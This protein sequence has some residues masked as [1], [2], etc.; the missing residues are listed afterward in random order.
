[1]TTTPVTPMMRNNVILVLVDQ[2]R[3]PVHMPAIQWDN[4]PGHKRLK[5]NGLRFSSYYVNTAPC[6]PSRSVIFTGWHTPRNL[7]TDNMDFDWIVP[8]SGDIPTLGDM[9]AAA[10]YYSVYKGKWHLAEIDDTHDPR[11]TTEDAMK[12]YG[13]NDYQHDGDLHSSGREGHTHDDKIMSEALYWLNDWVNYREEPAKGTPF[14]LVVGLVNP[15]DI[16]AVDVGQGQPAGSDEFMAVMSPPEHALYKQ[17]H[18]VSMPPSWQNDFI[19]GTSQRK[20]SAHAEADLVNSGLLG[21]IPKAR[22]DQWKAFVNYYI[23]CHRDVDRQIV[24]LL[25]YLRDT[26]LDK[27]TTVIFTADHGEI[28]GSHGMRNKG[29]YIYRENNH[30]PLVICQPGGP[31]GVESN[32]VASSLD[33]APTLN[34]L[35]GND[36]AYAHLYGAD[37]SPAILDP[38]W[39]GPTRDGVLYTYTA[40]SSVDVNI[41]TTGEIDYNKRGFLFGIQTKE[42][43][44]ARY[45]SPNTYNEYKGR[46][47]QVPY[48]D[49]TTTKFE[50]ELYRANDPDEIVNLAYDEAQQ[51]VVMSLND[52]LN[53]LLRQQLSGVTWNPVP[54]ANLPAASSYRVDTK[55]FR[56]GYR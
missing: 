18:G 25:D 43:K 53:A 44:F 4:L 24:R 1:M 36:V 15:H 35:F 3:M 32:V 56:A 48:S 20:P 8:M 50:L 45:F 27:T 9:A 54:P 38:T 33:L 5:D 17:D 49:I 39:A 19:Q 16:M 30:V 22:E 29:P 51:S 46:D 40:L 6:T 12:A 26:G 31:K 21:A 14:F 2:E 23:N 13:F 10:G 11:A 7:M 34:A 41:L 37:L 52:Q 42:W 55:A 28:G 47:H